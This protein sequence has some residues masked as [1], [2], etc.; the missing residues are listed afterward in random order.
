MHE[1]ESL[2]LYDVI[3]SKPAAEKL[4]AFFMAFFQVLHSPQGYDRQAARDQPNEP[5][6]GADRPLPEVG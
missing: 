4:R 1:R 3:L 6:H 5:F 2:R